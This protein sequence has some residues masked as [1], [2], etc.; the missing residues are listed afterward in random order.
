MGF[1][2]IIVG[3]EWEYNGSSWI[4]HGAIV[5]TWDY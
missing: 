4:V 5:P 3:I 2:G 1:D